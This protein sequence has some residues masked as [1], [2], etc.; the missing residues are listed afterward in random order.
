MVLRTT[1]FDFATGLR[2]HFVHN[3]LESYVAGDDHNVPGLLKKSDGNILAFYAAHNRL[4]GSEGDRSY[5]RTYDVDNETWS[6]ESEYH[7]WDFIPNSAP[8]AGGTNILQCLS[9]FGRRSRRGR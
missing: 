3:D 8:G 1:H 2:T 7:W 4:G 9:A 5:Y 6:V